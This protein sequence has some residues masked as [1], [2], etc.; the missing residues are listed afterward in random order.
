MPSAFN[1]SFVWCMQSLSTNAR[2]GLLK[3]RLRIRCQK[4]K[5]MRNTPED[6]MNVPVP[7]RVSQL[8]RPMLTMTGTSKTRRK[9]A[10]EPTGTM[11]KQTATNMLENT[12]AL[13][14]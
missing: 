2:S 4:K 13:R 11:S 8:L 6:T 12:A 1:I 7:A 10:V 14:L 5:K 3:I 9:S